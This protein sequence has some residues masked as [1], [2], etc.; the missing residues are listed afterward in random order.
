MS[1]A[2]A[3]F[4]VKQEFSDAG[5]KKSA[6]VIMGDQGATIYVSDD[7][8]ENLRKIQKAGRQLDSLGVT[9]VQLQG[10][11]W[12]F[13]RQWAFANGYTDTRS[14]NAIQWANDS[15]TLGSMR[16]LVNWSRELTNLPPADIYP[17]SLAKR[18]SEKLQ[19]IAPDHVSTRVISGDELL[20]E[21]W[22]GIHTVGRGS[23]HKPCMLI[24]DYNPSQQDDTP[25]D[26]V[27]VGKGITFDSGGYSI[28]SS[29]GMLAMK[30]DMGG[31]ATVAGALGLAMQKGLQKRVQLVLC[32]AENLI[33][34]TAYKLGDVITY[35]N[36]TTVEVVNTDA[37]GRL[38]LADGLQYAGEVGA[39]LVM[40]AA[41]L[42]GAAQM[43][44]GNEYNALFSV[45]DELANKALATAA[46]Q[47]ENLWR[48]PLHNWHKENT[49]SAFA[50]CAN[51][52]PQKGG[53][54][55]GASNAAGFLLRFA[56]NNGKGWLHFDIAGAYHNSANAMWAT[57]AT[58]L[59][60]RTIA[61][62]LHTHSD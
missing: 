47:R 29:E 45:D 44:V 58:A 31:A 40:D 50:D 8:A 7:E 49:P 34:G 2:L 1:T 22:I 37:E 27:L 52:R 19:A 5:W 57:G 30:C 25:V 16:E 17:A 51:S 39:K 28:K 3:V 32:C 55:G 4:I 6:A 13:E 62:L 60:M 48:L 43:A 54:A 33:D 14:T 10:S 24:V 35:K 9:Q 38:V 42:T 36:G 21:G 11:D 15:E 61:A 18:V 41:T 26:A 46:K 20:D 56:P 59:G 23:K 12:D 53:G